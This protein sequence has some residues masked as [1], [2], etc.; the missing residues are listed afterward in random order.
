MKGG[1]GNIPEKK[2]FSISYSL[3]S[4]NSV[5][6]HNYQSTLADCEN[7]L[8]V[9]FRATVNQLDF[10]GKNINFFATFI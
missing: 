3:Y 2:T 6:T 8:G 4:R 7:T 5:L 10:P 9:N 1:G